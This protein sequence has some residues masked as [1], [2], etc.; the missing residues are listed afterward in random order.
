MN[1]TDKKAQEVI[2]RTALRNL[3]VQQ[4]QLARLLPIDKGEKVES[5]VG[6]MNFAMN[7]IKDAAVLFEVEIKGGM[8]T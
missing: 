8:R 7:A 1:N 3:E 2:L 5:A 6:H 4:I